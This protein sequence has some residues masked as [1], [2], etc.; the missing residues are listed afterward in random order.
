MQHQ[1]RLFVLGLIHHNDPTR[2]KSQASQAQILRESLQARGFRIID[3]EEHEQSLKSF[4]A[5]SKLLEFPRIF[6]L[7]LREEFE[8]MRHSRLRAGRKPKLPIRKKARTAVRVL[9]LFA[10]RSR[11]NEALLRFEI[12]KALA[13]KHLAVWERT[14]KEKAFGAI[15]LE[16]DFSL[17]YPDSGFRIADLLDRSAASYD[18][19]DLAGGLTREE[20]S[21]PAARGEDIE[22]KLYVANTTCAYFV[23]A[24]T[25]ELLSE[26]AKV[27]PRDLYFSPDFF[28]SGLSKSD[29][30]GLTLLPWDLP[31]VHGSRE[32]KVESSIPY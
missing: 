7:Q 30:T 27:S 20:L 4:T 22:C 16:D 29:S 32:G 26:R 6:L 8:G 18:L 2:V 21:L 31:L 19:V 14:A 11:F 10:R 9:S 13:L 17:R 23:N 25:C 24:R 28:I 3:V 1:D 5:L 12:Q 15:L